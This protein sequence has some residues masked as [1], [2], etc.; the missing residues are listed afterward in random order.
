M[1]L[2]DILNG[3]LRRGIRIR[4]LLVLLLRLLSLLGLLLSSALG[5]E[6]SL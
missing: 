3:A 5:G 4:H 1:H 6:L 2:L